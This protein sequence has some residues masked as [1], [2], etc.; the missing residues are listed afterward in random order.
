MKKSQAGNIS[1]KPQKL[2]QRFRVQTVTFYNWTQMYCQLL[3]GQLCISEIELYNHVAPQKKKYREK[4]FSYSDTCHS[5]QLSHSC[6]LKSSIWLL[7]CWHLTLFLRVQEIHPTKTA[8]G[9]R[10]SSK[11]KCT[12]VLFSDKC[13]RTKLGLGN[14]V[15]SVT[16]VLPQCCE[17]VWVSFCPV[18][19]FS[20]GLGSWIFGYSW[21]SE[22]LVFCTWRKE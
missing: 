9:N 13:Q 14:S 22:T 19:R 20:L 7:M 5:L 4:S 16:Y 11:Q 2:F 15:A 1:K 18:T 17:S 3:S 8:A 21:F 12:T 6:L 10:L